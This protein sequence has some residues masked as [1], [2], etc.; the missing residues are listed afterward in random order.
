MNDALVKAAHAGTGSHDDIQ[1]GLLYAIL[2]ENQPGVDIMVS[3]LFRLWV[4]M[5]ASLLLI[6]K[7]MVMMIIMQTKLTF[8]ELS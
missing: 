2:T 8:L 4:K 7:C 1:A 3:M 5:C 6:G